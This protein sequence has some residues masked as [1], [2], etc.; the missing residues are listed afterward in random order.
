LRGC[1]DR[2]RVVVEDVHRRLPAELEILLERENSKDCCGVR[3]LLTG[4]VLLY[5]RTNEN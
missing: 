1:A 2:D 5:I 3:F 4:S